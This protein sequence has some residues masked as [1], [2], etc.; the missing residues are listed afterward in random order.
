MGPILILLLKM[1]PPGEQDQKE[2]E[3]SPGDQNSLRITRIAQHSTSPLS[4]ESFLTLVFCLHSCMS[5][6]QLASKIKVC[7]VCNKVDGMSSVLLAQ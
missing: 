1:S 5:R 6:T 3:L 4:V 7:F 2:L